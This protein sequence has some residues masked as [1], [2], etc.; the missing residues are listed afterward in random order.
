MKHADVRTVA[1]Y[2]AGPSS[3]TPHLTHE[4]TAAL[5]ARDSFIAMI[6]HELRNSV[7]PML[8]LAEQFATLVH[9]P[10]APPVVASRAAVLT[11]H[12]NKLVTT[13]ERVA[14]VGD[15]RRGRL[16]LDPTMMDLVEV[17]DEVC[18]EVRRE[19]EAARAELVVESGGPVI[20]SWDRGRVKQIA[21]NLISNAIRYGGG[22]RVEISVRDRGSDAELAIRDHGPGIEPVVL[23]HLFDRFDH[24]RPRRAGGFG[25]GLW[26]VKTVCAAMH[27][28]V[29]AANGMSGGAC[30]CVV[31]PRG[32]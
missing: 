4:L 20:G 25:I 23:A 9:D 14:E 17:V 8:L 31:L 30:F 22:G 26:V 6:G 7:A 12:L 32:R 15:L 29:T 13:V 2:E 1:L 11:R 10:Q 3:E 27:G 16:H 5:A 19:A 28:S 21:S 18:R 24:D